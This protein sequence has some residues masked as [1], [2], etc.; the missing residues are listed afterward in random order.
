MSK[1]IKRVVYKKGGIPDSWGKHVIVKE[2]SKRPPGAL[3][4][5]LGEG[6]RAP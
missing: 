5:W 2:K 3:H 6:A 1:C 4:A